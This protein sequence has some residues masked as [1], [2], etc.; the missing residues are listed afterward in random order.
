MVPRA[1]PDPNPSTVRAS[2]APS[3]KGLGRAPPGAG[4]SQHEP[5]LPWPGQSISGLSRPLSLAEGLRLG[6]LG[7]G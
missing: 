1:R 4:A 5:P 2:E 6:L 3:H 7:R